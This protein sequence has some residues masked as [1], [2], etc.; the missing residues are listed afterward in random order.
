MMAADALATW[1]AARIPAEAAAWLTAGAT[2]LRAGASDRELFLMTSLVGRKLGHAPLG[3]GSAELATA[4]SIRAGWD[5]S[6]WTID[7]AARIF[8]LLVATPDADE[9]V[10][11]LDRLCAAAD[12][13]ELV[14]WYR[15]LPLY[16]DPPRHVM[17]AAEGVR[18]NMRTVFE[19]VA[20][21]NPYPSEQFEEGAWNQMV[22]KALFVGARLDLVV[23]LDA[24][25]NPPLAR[26]LCDYAHERWAASRTI[27]PELWR[28]VGPFARGEG[29]DDFRRLLSRGTSQERQ[30][31]VL[32]LLE[33]PDPAAKEL[34]RNEPELAAAAR[35]NEFHWGTLAAGTA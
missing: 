22:L 3:L 13:G 26:M 19:A 16:P 30:A 34:L 15:G 23:G 14:A 21:R 17:R 11:R 29:L 4:A 28:C 7:Q 20:H 2:R 6:D 8:L 27:S 10:R 35:A 31:A 33:S 9:F 12:V 32:A 5:P 1:L 25:R 24:R 18:S